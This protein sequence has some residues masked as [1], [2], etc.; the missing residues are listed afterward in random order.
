MHHSVS[1]ISAKKRVVMASDKWARTLSHGG[2][3]GPS[4]GVQVSDKS[5]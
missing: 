3:S 1:G 5:V 4:A 2:A